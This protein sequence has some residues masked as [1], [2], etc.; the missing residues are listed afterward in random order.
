MIYTD[1]LMIDDYLRH[2]SSQS[3]SAHSALGAV[4]GVDALYKLTFYLL[5]YFYFT[6][7]SEINDLI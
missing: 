1:Y 6:V 5:T 3:T 7:L 4:L 2:S